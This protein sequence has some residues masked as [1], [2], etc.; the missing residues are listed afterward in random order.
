MTLDILSQIFWPFKYL[1]ETKVQ[2]LLVFEDIE[3]Q[4]NQTDGKVTEK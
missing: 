3:Y 1:H 2:H 4:V